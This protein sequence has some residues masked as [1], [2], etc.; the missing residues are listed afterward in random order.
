MLEKSFSFLS[1]CK[2]ISIFTIVTVRISVLRWSA[3]TSL[4]Q[5]TSQC[6]RT[7]SILSLER[8]VVCVLN[9]NI[10]FLQMLK[11]KMSGVA[12]NFNN[13]GTRLHIIFLTRQ[14]VEGNSR[15]LERNIRGNAPL[16]STV[17]NWV[18]QFKGGNFSTWI[19]P[20]PGRLRTE[21]TP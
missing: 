6:R 11:G 7:E 21:T 14:G 3:D 19:A 10:F 8:G 18:A 12:R 13:I 2:S 20:R 1:F 4:G 17:K 15:H 9:C 5:H 16:Y